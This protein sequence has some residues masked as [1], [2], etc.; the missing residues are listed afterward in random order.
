MIIDKI[1]ALLAHPIHA[2]IAVVIAFI[3]MILAGAATYIAYNPK[4]P[5]ASPPISIKKSLVLRETKMVD[6]DKSVQEAELKNYS[7]SHTFLIYYS[8]LNDGDVPITPSDFVESITISTSPDD[9]ISK[10]VGKSVEGNRASGAPSK[11][12]Q[13]DKRH[14]QLQP[15]LLNKDQQVPFTVTLVS[16]S[17]TGTPE[18]R[19]KLDYQ[20]VGIS[21]V[22]IIDIYAAAPPDP[23][24]QMY[25]SLLQDQS[26]RIRIPLWQSIIDFKN[27]SVWNFLILGMILY[28]SSLGLLARCYH[29]RPFDGYVV[30][31]V[32][33]LLV[34]A[35]NTSE[36]IVCTYDKGIKSLVL[37]CYPAFAGYLIYLGYLWR[38]GSK[39]IKT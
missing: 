18:S 37:L 25:M 30:L 35:I 17:K 21:D 9:E 3:S 4:P 10:V 15:V 32:L 12:M 38:R 2:G 6:V 23:F 13:I 28:G 22:N 27:V 36:I 19:I 34:F 29:G 1:R 33:V 5:P 7:P 26:P 31:H 14:W 11:W 20:I 39:P 16:S 8:L 24:L